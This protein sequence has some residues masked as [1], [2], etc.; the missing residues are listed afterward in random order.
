MPLTHENSAMQTPSIDLNCRADAAAYAVLRRLAAAIRHQMAGNFQPVTML[1]TVM[2]KRLLAATVD[3]PALVKTSSDV[4]AMATAAT[5]SS[6][7]LLGWIAPDLTAR[8]PLNSGIEEALHLVATELSF[9]GFKCDNQTEG[10]ATQVALNHVRS[11]FVT[12]LLALTDEAQ[13]PASLRLTAQNQADC[14]AVKL[15]LVPFGV[16]MPSGAEQQHDVFQPTVT[17]YRKIDWQDVQAIA[18]LNAVPI[19]RSGAAVLLR[20][21]NALG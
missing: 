15:A 20:I 3:L 14:V 1:A 2:E 21:P 4:K 9:R 5:R 13:S 19:E 8:V 12:A 17:P 18:A 16:D 7:D 6:L 10:M 11:V